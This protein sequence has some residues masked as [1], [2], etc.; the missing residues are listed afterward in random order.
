MGINLE[1][2]VSR[3]HL[4]NYNQLPP[5]FRTSSFSISNAIDFRQSTLISFF[6]LFYLFK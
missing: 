3:E 2:N 1:T 6:F 4:Q 5:F